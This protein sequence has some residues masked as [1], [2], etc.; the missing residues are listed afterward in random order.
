MYYRF[1][2]GSE[3]LTKRYP[4]RCYLVAANRLARVSKN[5]FSYTDHTE[6]SMGAVGVAI[7]GMQTGGEGY[8]IAELTMPLPVCLQG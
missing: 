2:M 8:G 5:V 1:R 4:V 3:Q 6:P 7:D